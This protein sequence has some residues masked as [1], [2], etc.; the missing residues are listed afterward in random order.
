MRPPFTCHAK[1]VSEALAALRT[2]RVVEVAFD[3][4][5][6]PEEAGE[7]YQVAQWIEE[8]AFLGEIG[9]MKWSI[10]SGNCARWKEIE[11]AMTNA[12]RFWRERSSRDQED[13]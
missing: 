3:N 10:H 2:G 11:C 1:T 9:P 7:G 8:K 12:E 5:L 4:D 13:P 6:G